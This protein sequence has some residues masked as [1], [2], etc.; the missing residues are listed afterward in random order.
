M[1]NV[2]TLT[3]TLGRM[4]CEDR[5]MDWSDV[6][7]SQGTLKIASNHQSPGKRHQTVSSSEP[8]VE[9]NPADTDLDF[10]PWGLWENKLLLF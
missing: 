7:I 9:T 5:G 6:L 4:P 3:E 8:P 1:E 2:E 10:Q